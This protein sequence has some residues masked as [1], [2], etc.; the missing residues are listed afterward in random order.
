M[1]FD[2]KQQ[3]QK[4]RDFVDNEVLQAYKIRRVDNNDEIATIARPESSLERER[5]TYRVFNVIEEK[6]VHAPILVFIEKVVP[7]NR[8]LWQRIQK[9][10]GYVKEGDL[11]G[12][13]GEG[14]TWLIL[15]ED[16][17]E[18]HRQ[19]TMEE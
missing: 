2:S 4:V 10:K 3:N 5:V 19:N 1:V 11:R 12:A 7:R 18:R 15:D 16:A 8:M 14:K 9:E 6:A 17:A 13:L